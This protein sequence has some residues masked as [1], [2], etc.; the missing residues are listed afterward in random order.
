VESSGTVLAICLEK[1]NYKK[2]NQNRGLLSRDEIILHKISAYTLFSQEIM[3]IPA[4][5]KRISFVLREG[6][7]RQFIFIKFHC[8]RYF[9]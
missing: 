3:T 5:A 9:Q 8:D 4:P 7:L 1:L 2:K 6:G